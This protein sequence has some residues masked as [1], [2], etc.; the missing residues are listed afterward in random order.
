MAKF[1]CP[2]CE[3]VEEYFAAWEALESIECCQTCGREYQLND[4][5]GGPIALEAT[6]IVDD[7]CNE[8]CA[9]NYIRKIS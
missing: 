8:N 6:P 3:E 4:S 1:N 7:T 5:E 9:H 2:H